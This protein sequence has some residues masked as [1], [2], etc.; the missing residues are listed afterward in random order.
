MKKLITVLMA[1]FLLMSLGACGKKE[2]SSEEDNGL[3]F[4]V[5]LDTG[6]GNPQEMEITSEVGEGFIENIEGPMSLIVSSYQ[7]DQGQFTQ[8]NGIKLED[9]AKVEVYV[10]D[11]LYTGDLKDLKIKDG[12]SISIVY[13]EPEQTQTAA[14]EPAGT[15][16]QPAA[17]ENANLLG[18]WE[19]YQTYEEHVTEEQKK[20]FEEAAAELT[21]VG[22]MPLRVLAT[23]IVSG[24]NYAFLCQGITVTAAPEINYYIIVVYVPFEGDNEIKAINKIDIGNIQLKEE[25]SENM[26]GGW[27]I[28]KADEKE[29]LSDKKIQESFKKAAEKWVGLDLIPMQ[30]L[31]TQLVSGTN[32][33]ALCYGT[34]V[35]EK[36]AS[37][38]YIVD[39]Y[40]DLQGNA[41]ISKVES[42][43]LA[44]YVA[45]E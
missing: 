44:Y 31:A 29:T 40:E 23:Q 18:G 28:M 2:E 35:T 13:K 10:N 42:L 45:G 15:T 41:S 30:V 38:L 32:Y 17:S 8:F 22:Y 36:P 34:T 19:V 21:G 43:N 20:I 5:S 33:K 16:E 11:E 6:D 12:D 9:G 7:I 14:Q 37:D 1:L 27:M 24:T 39:W 26:L 4:T 25:S 3:H